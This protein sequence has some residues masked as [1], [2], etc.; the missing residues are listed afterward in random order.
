MNN[1]ELLSELDKT[2]SGHKKAKIHLINLINT[3]KIRYNQKWDVDRGAD[4]T[5]ADLL[6]TGKMLLLGASGTGK[7]WL[8]KELARV[9]DFPLLQIDATRLNPTGA[10]KGIRPEDLIKLIEETAKEAM[11][12]NP[13]KYWSLERA[14][15][16]M[17]VFVDEVCKLANAFDSSGTWNQQIQ[18]SL[19]T[20]IDNREELAGVT[21]IFAGAFTKLYSRK[22]ES[23]GQVKRG[24]GFYQTT[25]EAVEGSD[26]GDEELI[27]HGLIAEFVGR[28]S[29]ICELDEFKREDYLDVLMSRVLPRKQKEAKLFNLNMQGP[30]QVDIDKILDKTVK[31]GLGV[32]GLKKE[33][34]ALYAEQ[35]FESDISFSSVNSVKSNVHVM[36]DEE[37]ELFSRG[38]PS[39]R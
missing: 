12:Q 27:K 8:V 3:S 31:G 34:D 35:L 23:A 22:K 26:I 17:V 38:T 2:V 28:L 11:H 7:T 6:H 16:C 18:S 13:K 32:R 5:D 19:L 25:A 36:D 30:S 29:C 15:D 20:I 1:R 9:M 24:I 39:Y 37:Y 21:W 14:M 4:V 10:H 33:V